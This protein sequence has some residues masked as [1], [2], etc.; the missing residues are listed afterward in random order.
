M[1]TISKAN[2]YYNYILLDPRVPYTWEYLG[3]QINFLPF[4]VGKGKN[5]RVSDHYRDSCPDNPYTKH[6]IAKL[7]AGGYINTYI[8][9]N[10]NSS[11]DLAYQ[12]EINAIKYIKDRFGSILTNITDGGDNPPVMVGSKNPKSIPVYQY[13]MNTGDFI[14][15]FESASLAATTLNFNG[16]SHICQCAKGQRNTA[17]NYIWRY[18]KVE[19]LN[20]KDFPYKRFSFSKL[21]AYNDKETYSFN[22]MKEAYDF[23]KVE[24]K[25]RINQVLKGDR[26][27]YKGF[28]WKIKV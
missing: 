1:E 28:Y 20:I 22:S 24:N 14:A 18:F 2:N 6:K 9:F 25:G 16:Y 7:K 15:E 23:L 19:K 12:E 27:T 13:D 4:Y 8:I 3:K 17:N 5:T 26:K 11:E 21:I 10:E